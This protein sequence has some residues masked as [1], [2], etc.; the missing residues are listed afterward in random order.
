MQVSKAQQQA[1]QR[2]EKTVTGGLD[3]LIGGLVGCLS[4]LRFRKMVA[5]FNSRSIYAQIIVMQLLVYYR[6]YYLRDRTFTLEC[7]LLA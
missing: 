5:W 4:Y 2:P 3:E 1:V 7:F 6:F